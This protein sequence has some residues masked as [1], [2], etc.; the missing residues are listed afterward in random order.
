MATEVE[1]LYRI[2]LKLQEAMK[3]YVDGNNINTEICTLHQ[4]WQSKDG[5]LGGI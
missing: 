1:G 4:I 2:S 3:S 5:Q